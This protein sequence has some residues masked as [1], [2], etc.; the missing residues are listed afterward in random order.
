MSS[1]SGI[2]EFLQFWSSLMAPPVPQSS[3]PP[4]QSTASSVELRLEF[5]GDEFGGA[6]EGTR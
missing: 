5:V 6:A 3:A 4:L 2:L 1:N